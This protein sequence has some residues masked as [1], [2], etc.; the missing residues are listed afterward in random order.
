MSSAKKVEATIS[1]KGQLVIPA[2]LREELGL[3]PG[4]KVLLQKVGTKL[5]LEPLRAVREREKEAFLCE[6]DALAKEIGEQWSSRL[7]AGEAVEE[8]R[9]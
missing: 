2:D 5:E 1:T 9:Q 7:S 6:L 4:T 8:Q 3:E